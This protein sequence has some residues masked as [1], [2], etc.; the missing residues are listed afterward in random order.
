MDWL[1]LD[2]ELEAFAGA[3]PFLPAT[4]LALAYI[5]DYGDSLIGEEIAVHA[6]MGFNRQ[7]SFSSGRRC[8][9]ATQAALELRPQAILRDNGAPIWPTDCVGSISHS[10]RIAAAVMSK[11]VIGVGVDVERQGRVHKKLWP[12]VFS[13][14][15]I[16]WLTDVPSICADVMF[17]AKEA[18]YKAVFPHGRRFIG[19]LDARIELDLSQQQFKIRYL[20][21]HRPN[22]LLDSGIGYWHR[23]DDHVLTIFVLE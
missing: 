4:A 8:V 18:G 22:S 5:K 23:A 10:N 17:S 1:F 3:M 16:A 11:S 13:E 20:G 15:E 12:S 9:R 7:L 6:A 2:S 19:F 21:D 14:T